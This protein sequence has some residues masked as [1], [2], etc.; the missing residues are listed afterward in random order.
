MLK[1]Q[2]L[3]IKRLSTIVDALKSDNR[4]YKPEVLES[5]QFSIFW[6]PTKSKLFKPNQFRL[7]IAFSE[8]MLNNTTYLFL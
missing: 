2:D 5:G 6:N 7:T 8:M 1:T 3:E 4:K